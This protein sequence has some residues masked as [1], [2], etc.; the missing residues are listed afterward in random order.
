M[1]SIR[2]A[3]FACGLILSCT[4]VVSASE[5]YACIVVADIAVT[6]EFPGIPV[7]R[8][9]NVVEDTEGLYEALLYGNIVEALPAKGGYSEVFGVDGESIGYAEV[10]ALAP[11]PKYA[12]FLPEPFRFAVDS[13]D[14]FLL[15]GSRPIADYALPGDA[16]FFVLAGEVTDGI[17][18]Y[19]DGGVEWTLLSFETETD[20]G[21]GLRY[22]WT[23][24]E[25]LTRLS[26][27]EPDVA[28][29]DP[30]L[31]PRRIRG[32]GPLDDKF[33]ES[34][35]RNG[36]A[37][38]AAPFSD[39]KTV[40][41]SLTRSYPDSAFQD[42]SPDTL[43]SSLNT[44]NF[45]TT[46]LFLH[47]FRLVFSRTLEEVERSGFAPGL[48]S[49]LTEA[50]GALDALGKKA[51]K[52]VFLDETF[53]RAR[54]FLTIPAVLLSPGALTVSDRAE[55]EIGKILKAEGTA[56]SEISGNPSENYA[57]YRPRGHYASSEELSRYFRAMTYLG[58]ASLL[59]DAAEEEKIRE[60][61]ALIALLSALFNDEKLRG[62]WNALHEPLSYLIG[63]A[64]A[65]TFPGCAPVVENI[66]NGR[67]RGLSDAKTLSALR[68]ALLGILPKPGA[69]GGPG[70]GT[71][72]NREAREA[73]GFRLMGR[74]FVLDGSVLDDGPPASFGAAGGA[75]LRGFPG[76]ADATA[77]PNSGSVDSASDWLSVLSYL[78]S[79]EEAASRQ[80]FWNAPLWEV[81]KLL[82]ASASWAELKRG[83]APRAEQGYTET[84]DGGV[85]E[86][87][88]FRVPV[89]R[90]YVEPAPQVFGAI[91]GALDRLKEVVAK[92]APG[93]NDGEA[94]EAKYR[95]EAFR[96]YTALFRDIAEREAREEPLSID[97][98]LVIDQAASYLNSS[99]LS[100]FG[101]APGFMAFISGAA[102]DGQPLYAAT[103]TPRRLYVYVDDKY[104][105]PRV[106]VGYTYSF[107]EFERLP[108]ESRVTDEAW[109][110]LVYD[111]KRQN[112][113]E[114]L[115][116]EWSRE[117]FAR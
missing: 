115:T 17:G 56:P 40:P 73:A 46:D 88:P 99:L 81:K 82:T 27:Y 11:L 43:N 112:E 72:S 103:G 70:S 6:T 105:G 67:L 93:T 4:V 91:S 92:F 16:P 9:G 35:L 14:L 80:F 96:E 31:V 87:E 66:L 95:I 54:D 68:E 7:I 78:F 22:A 47:T 60:N 42:R 97:D 12:P 24:S 36:F 98:Y 33:Y 69:A 19:T 5:P 51:P 62:R 39:E 79:K 110:S 116:P 53:E 77:A 18:T 102:P 28:K 86:V 85:W 106:T 30:A 32:A 71:P 104:S 45:I 117:I 29:V 3:L 90:G 41:D 113:L 50:L 52:N 89:P 61:T 59:P 100:D 44:P 38:D 1:K 23:R 2:N 74:R 76:A 114:R 15:P 37:V 65:P 94:G 84:D 13:P 101:F 21:V 58:R 107:Y 48:A 83:A 49:F 34:L 64:E 25:N 109:K 75:V 111:K 26:A 108:A 57:L 10:S 8:N 55:R 20:G 63:E